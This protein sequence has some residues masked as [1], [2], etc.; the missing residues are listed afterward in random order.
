MSSYEPYLCPLIPDDQFTAS[1]NKFITQVR[2]TYGVQLAS[3]LA[4]VT[5]LDHLI[6][7]DGAK[8][9]TLALDGAGAFLGE[10][11]IH[12]ACGHWIEHEC[13]PVVGVSFLVCDPF[14]VVNDRLAGDEQ[15]LAA[16][17]T[18]GKEIAMKWG[19]PR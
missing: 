9:N 3:G 2:E 12:D 7:D 8:K 19:C 18:F 5:Q 13:K 16:C 17:V 11:L 1:A 15:P 10:A 6:A 4:G 14:K